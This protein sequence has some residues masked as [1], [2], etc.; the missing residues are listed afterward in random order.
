MTYSTTITWPEATLGCPLRSSYVAEM[1]PMFERSGQDMPG[2]PSFIA[3]RRQEGRICNVEF[4]WST[5]QLAVFEEFLA[6]DLAGGLAGF[7]M[8]Q[9]ADG[10]L[11]PMFCNYAGAYQLAPHPDHLGLSRATFQVTAW[12]RTAAS[13]DWS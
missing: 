5:D 13:P 10:Q 12:W 3:S 7:M 2:A 9:L 6:V 1:A 4:L 11:R 8:D